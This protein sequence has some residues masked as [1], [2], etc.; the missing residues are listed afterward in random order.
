MTVNELKELLDKYDGGMEILTTAH[1]PK[2]LEES[3]IYDVWI[4]KTSGIKDSYTYGT[5]D[6]TECLMFDF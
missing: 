4:K 6:D 2:P 3:R 1:K 5:A